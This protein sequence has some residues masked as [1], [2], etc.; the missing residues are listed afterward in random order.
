M[1]RN[2]WIVDDYGICP[3]GKPDT[4]FYCGAKIGTEHKKGC[5]L[6][7]RTIKVQMTL[8]FVEDVP[9]DWEEDDI[10]FHYNESSWCANN[11]LNKLQYRTENVGC[12]C[13]CV[14]FKYVGEATEEDEYKWKVKDTREFKKS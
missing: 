5:V 1:K 6:R 8:E 12:L 3:A 7:R 14:D 13:D 9:E 4:C 2:N 11:I 10:N